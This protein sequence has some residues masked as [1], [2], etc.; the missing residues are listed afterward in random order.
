M[1]PVIGTVSSSELDPKKG[2]SAR[3]YLFSARH[4]AKDYIDAL[5]KRA[6]VLNRRSL[7]MKA[8]EK[9]LIALLTKAYEAGRKS[10]A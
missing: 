8:L 7:F 2:L 5:C 3:K 6:V 4:E 1:A 10:K 9:E